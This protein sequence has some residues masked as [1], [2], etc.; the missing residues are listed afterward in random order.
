MNPI[1]LTFYYSHSLSLRI[2]EV[3]RSLSIKKDQH[4]FPLFFSN[5]VTKEFQI[6]A[7]NVEGNCFFLLYCI[8]LFEILIH[9][10][11]SAGRL[12]QP[13]RAVACFG[14]SIG[15]SIALSMGLFVAVSVGPYFSVKRFVYLSVHR[16][17][18]LPVFPRLLGFS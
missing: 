17:V 4:L 12:G 15:L 6:R 16:F 18:Q 8:L 11:I 7:F 2:L 5:D 1:M 13:C 14:L 10:I 9:K 3:K